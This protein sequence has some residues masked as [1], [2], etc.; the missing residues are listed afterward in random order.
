MIKKIVINVLNVIT[1]FSIDIIQQI[2]KNV[3]TLQ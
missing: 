2:L 3:Y 1:A